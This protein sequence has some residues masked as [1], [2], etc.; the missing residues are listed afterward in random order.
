MPNHIHCIIV[1]NNNVVAGLNINVG[2]GLN[3]KVGAGLKPAP[4]DSVPQF[5]SFPMLQ[6]LM[7]YERLT[8]VCS[9]CK[10][11]PSGMPGTTGPE[12]RDVSL[13]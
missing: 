3:N 13:I 8:L 6:W 10:T 9:A 1:I 12:M 4:T 7:T 5:F 2:A 11:T